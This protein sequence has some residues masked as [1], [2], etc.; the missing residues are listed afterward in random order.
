MSHSAN[1]E[2]RKNKKA[3]SINMSNYHFHKHR[4][5]KPP[6][7]GQPPSDPDFEA[8]SLCDYLHFTAEKTEAEGNKEICFG[9]VKL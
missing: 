6:A 1:G 4:A 8:C 2:E 3:N 7:R 5:A 9:E